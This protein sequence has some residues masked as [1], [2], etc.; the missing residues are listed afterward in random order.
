MSTA[1]VTTAVVDE[2]SAMRF[3]FGA[4]LKARDTLAVERD[5][6]RRF[7]TADR[8]LRRAHNAVQKQL[9]E[10]AVNLH[11]MGVSPLE[12]KQLMDD[13]AMKTARVAR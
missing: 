5:Q 11:S 10:V 4:L 13:S 12:L 8:R 2:L 3:A 9:Q 7:R 1:P 6:T